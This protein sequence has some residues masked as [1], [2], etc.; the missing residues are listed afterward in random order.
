MKTVSP[1][2]ILSMLE[3]REHEYDSTWDALKRSVP[4]TPFQKLLDMYDACIMAR[5]WVGGLAPRAAWER[6]DPSQ[7][8]G[9]V[10]TNDWKQWALTEV[11]GMTTADS[12]RLVEAGK[13]NW[14][15]V[16]RINTIAHER[17]DGYET[18]IY[19]TDLDHVE[20][21]ATQKSN[22]LM[23]RA[24]VHCYD[25][26]RAFREEFAPEWRLMRDTATDAERQARQ[27]QLYAATPLAV[28]KEEEIEEEMDDEIENNMDGEI[29]DDD[30]K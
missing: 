30:D 12:L 13:W 27:A 5:I 23:R 15:L 8:R 6:D 26:W 18:L 17:T 10:T 28:R 1:Y 19:K 16:D 3:I 21:E 25:V 7:D 24:A 11:F 2:P 20:D 22:E 14:E 4:N 9:F 29:P